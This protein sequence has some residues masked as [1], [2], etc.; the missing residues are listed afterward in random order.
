MIDEV[1]CGADAAPAGACA[2]PRSKS[3]TSRRSSPRWRAC[4]SRAC[5]SDDTELLPQHRRRPARGSS[6]A[7]TGR[8]TRSRRRSSWPGPACGRRTSRSAVV[9]VCWSRPASAEDR[10]WHA[11]SRAS[12]ASR[13]SASTCRSTWSATAV[14]RL[15]GAPPGYVGYDGGRPADRQG[16]T[17]IR[18]AS[19]CSTRSRRRIRTCSASC[20]R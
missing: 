8:S 14:S 10:G 19:C 15:I 5:R 9:P 2:R 3:P 18:T 13:S 17:R 7:R 6:S 1:R 11:S 16:R 20:C 4:R 12:S